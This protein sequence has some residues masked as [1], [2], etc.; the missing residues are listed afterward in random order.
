VPEKRLENRGGGGWQDVEGFRDQVEG[1][2][3]EGRLSVKGVR[4]QRHREN[5]GRGGVGKRGSGSG[6]IKETEELV[7]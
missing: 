4:V 6:E 2:K 5:R 3:P 1:R 7:S